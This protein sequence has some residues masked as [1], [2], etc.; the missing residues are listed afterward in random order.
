MTP[1]ILNTPMSLLF[2]DTKIIIEEIRLK[3]ATIIISKRIKNITFFST[4]SALNNEGFNSRQSE[5]LKKFG[6]FFFNCVCFSSS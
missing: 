2:I 1:N 6:I 5:I 4:S 3:A